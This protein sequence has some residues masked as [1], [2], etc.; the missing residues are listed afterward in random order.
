MYTASIQSF[1]PG[2]ERPTTKN[3][4]SAPRYA[5]GSSNSE[6]I[7]LD[8]SEWKD[9]PEAIADWFAAVERIEPTIGAEG[10]EEAYERFRND[11][12]EF[13]IEAV[14]MQMAEIPDGGTP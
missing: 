5:A 1:A 14:R 4:Q 10:Q 8:E 12:R 11:H 2:D 6:K 9:T 3:G 7:G 13:N